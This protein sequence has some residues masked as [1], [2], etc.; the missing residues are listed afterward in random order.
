MAALPPKPDLPERASGG[1]ILQVSYRT[2]NAPGVSRPNF[3]LLK[4]PADLNSRGGGSMQA[5]RSNQP[6]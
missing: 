3:A 5:Q 4:D 2:D 6:S 1:A